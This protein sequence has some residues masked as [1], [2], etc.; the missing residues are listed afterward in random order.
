MIEDIIGDSERQ[1]GDNFAEGIALEGTVHDVVLRRV[2]MMN[3]HDSIHEY[4]NG[5][6]FVT[7]GRVY[8]VLFEDTVASGS[9]DSG[10]DLK[11]SATTL[12]RARAEDNARNFKI[13]GDSII[14]N[15]VSRNPHKR[16]GNGKQNHFWVGKDANVRVT[17]CQIEDSDTIT[18]A[19]EVH[20]QIVVQNSTVT[21]SPSA[22]LSLIGDSG[23]LD[24]VPGK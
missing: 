23:S 20:G 2:T 3:S 10:Y 4:W 14:L 24:I 16:G 11:S 6:G 19:F 18:T 21:I 22:R 12:L 9:T 13:W 5:D 17:G 8:N 1:D 7:E 15:C